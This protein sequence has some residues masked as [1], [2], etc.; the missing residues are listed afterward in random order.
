MHVFHYERARSELDRLLKE[1]DYRAMRALLVVMNEV[2]VA[3]FLNELELPQAALLF[4]MLPKDIGL[5]VFCHLDPDAQEAL[6]TAYSDT[7][8]R[9]VVSNLYNDDLVDLM[10]ELPAMLAK[11]VLANT[12][13][14]RRDLVNK[15]LQYPEDSA[16]SIMT[17]EYIHLRQD[18]TVAESIE[19]IR[20]LGAK[21]E[22]M[23]SCF[24][25]T[26]D[27][28]LEGVITLREL[29][30]SKDEQR[31]GDLMERSVISVT[32]MDDREYVANCFNRY[33]LL[34]IPVTDLENRLVG[35]ITVDDALD[36]MTEEA[37]E[38]LSLM[39]AVKPAERPYLETSVWD[40]ARRRFFW[41][42]FLML[43]GILNGLILGHYEAAFIS[44][45]ILV[46][47]M[48][49]LTDTGGNA[50]SQSSGL[51]IRA[52]AVGEVDTRDWAKVL[53]KELRIGVLTGAI[54]ALING[55]R[56]YLFNG[57]NL[58]LAL[59]V[60][61]ALFFIVIMSKL[62]GAA[63]PLLADKLGLDPAIMAAPL[64]TTIVDSLGLIVY[65]YTATS[66]LL[67]GV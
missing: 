12:P 47:F 40:N 55:L 52:L 59:T 22:M 5:D 43:S 41:L 4:R 32:T 49:M 31:V 8:I 65:F 19:R 54:L 28:I 58:M 36:V 42:L 15:L 35:I 1:G 24:V 44:L 64:I 25:T 50:G 38:D 46:S 7:E 21:S 67:P 2:D 56:I 60:S 16:G 29:L 62:I 53:W 66:L 20:R 63:L 51:L 37:T 23:Y 27:R 30:T 14:D 18:M 57:H 6:I 3:E 9:E 13:K 10:E 61:L 33:G 34:A 39:S 17:T 48:P 11:R 26:E 45:P